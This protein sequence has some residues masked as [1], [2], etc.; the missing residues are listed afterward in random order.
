M[1]QII[2]SITGTLRI[3]VIMGLV[4][5]FANFTITQNGVT[6]DYVALACGGLAVL[7]ALVSIA[8]SL[9]VDD[10]PVRFAVIGVALVLG[11]V[12]LMRGIGLF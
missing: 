12:Q 1:Q 10:K 8:P 4:P 11:M 3:A 5:F 7:L 9:S 2:Q 6:R